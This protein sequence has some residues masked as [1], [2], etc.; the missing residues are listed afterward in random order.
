MRSLRTCVDNNEDRLTK[1]L[2]KLPTIRSFTDDF[3]EDVFFVGFLGDI[4]IN[5][6][7]PYVLKAE[8]QLVKN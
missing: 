7:I 1:L 4:C 2:L 8:R 5:D 3:L 6:A